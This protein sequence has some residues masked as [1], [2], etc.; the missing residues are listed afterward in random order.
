M[1]DINYTDEDRPVPDWTS[2]GCNPTPWPSPCWIVST[3]R[4]GSTWLSAMLN[5]STFRREC[6][7]VPEKDVFCEHF[8][9][10]YGHTYPHYEP[11]VTKVHVNWL[12][13]PLLVQQLPSLD[14]KIILLTRN[15]H[16]QQV[17]SMI[18]SSASKIFNTKS[19]DRRDTYRQ[20]LMNVRVSQNE[21][22]THL[23]AID[24]WER[25]G[26][27]LFTHHNIYQ[28]S[29]EELLASPRV[30]VEAVLSWMGM[31]ASDFSYQE[32]EFLRLRCS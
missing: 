13:D 11:I 17:W 23:A 5:I 25:L 29:Y 20:A 21:L 32:S 9:P 15:D 7:E 4:S 30:W 1:N 2:A 10:K 16:V 6:P 22:T 31:S 24:R 3:P 8:H 28:L 18:A 26:K 27:F 14:T 19:E 12:D